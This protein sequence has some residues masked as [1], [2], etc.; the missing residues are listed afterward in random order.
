MYV[1]R[2]HVFNGLSQELQD[3]Y[4]IQLTENQKK[5]II[6]V[7]T[8]EFPAGASKKTYADCIFIEKEKDESTDYC[9]SKIFA[10]MLQ[11]RYF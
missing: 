2:F 9:I 1:Q 10:K 7:L 3:N 5:N 6:N 11:N 4:G 8:N